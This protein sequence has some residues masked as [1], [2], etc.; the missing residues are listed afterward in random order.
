MVNICINVG[1]GGSFN[2]IMCIHQK[3]C[4]P[5]LNP[6]EKCSLAVVVPLG[7]FRVGEQLVLSTTH[8]PVMT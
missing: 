6:N 2:A 4:C 7:P 8:V 1:Q 5:T 3:K